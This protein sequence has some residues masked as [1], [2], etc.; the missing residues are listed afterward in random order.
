MNFLEAFIFQMSET[1]SFIPTVGED[2]NG[3]L[4]SNREGQTLQVDNPFYIVT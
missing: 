4:A 2:I 1:K 3:N